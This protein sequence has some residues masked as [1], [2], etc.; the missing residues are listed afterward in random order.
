MFAGYRHPHPLE[1]LIE[2]KVR[3]NGDKDAPQAMKDACQELVQELHTLN[4]RF[5]VS[6]L[7]E[8]YCFTDLYF[9]GIT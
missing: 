5:K 7:F 6:S 8:L 2:M 4:S 1:R 9:K 3:T